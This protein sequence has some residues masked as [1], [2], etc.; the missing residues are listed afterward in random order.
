[1]LAVRP[2]G[3]DQVQQ[4][5]THSGMMV[6]TWWAV[7]ILL[8]AFPASARELTEPKLGGPS[9]HRV[10]IEQVPSVVG[11]GNNTFAAV[12]GT[13]AQDT[14]RSADQ[15]DLEEVSLTGQTH[16]TNTT[17][18][19]EVRGPGDNF[20]KVVGVIFGLILFTSAIGLVVRV[21][22]SSEV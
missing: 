4:G 8:A 12:V 9:S 13:G 2:G 10:R 15:F 1:M 18:R 3:R 6:C 17:H 11:V 22:R 20:Q 14:R 7:G 19:R 16:S 5:L 21:Q